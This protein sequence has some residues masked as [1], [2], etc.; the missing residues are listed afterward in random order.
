LYVTLERYQTSYY[1]VFGS[2]YLGRLCESDREQTVR[3]TE[4][5]RL[6]PHEPDVWPVQGTNLRASDY[7]KRLPDNAD[8]FWT[9]RVRSPDA[10]GRCGLVL[11]IG[12]CSG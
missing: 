4:R 12:G 10:S 2:R 7:Q 8:Q 6:V 11:D 3:S 1:G 5:P 9:S